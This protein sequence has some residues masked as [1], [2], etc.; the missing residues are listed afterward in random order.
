MSYKVIVILLNVAWNALHGMM[1]EIDVHG[2]VHA[3]CEII[4]Q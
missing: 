3:G 1:I 4:D 2:P